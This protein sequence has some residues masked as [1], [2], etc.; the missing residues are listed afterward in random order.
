MPHYENSGVFVVK[1]NSAV[2]KINLTMGTRSLTHFVEEGETLAT[3]YRQ[4]DGYLSGHG[5][6]LAEFLKG[7]NIVNGY[8]GDTTNLANGMGCLTA[9]FIAHIKEGCGNIYLYPPNS[10]N[11]WEEYTYSVYLKDNQLN[12]KAVKYDNEVVFEGTPEELLDKNLLTLK[13]EDNA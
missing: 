5:N 9:Q 10:E 12:I 1:G 7:F 6:D 2:I 3:I 11:C 4:F 8:S 13:N